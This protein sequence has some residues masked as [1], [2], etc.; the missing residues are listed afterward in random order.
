MIR[1]LSR[2]RAVRAAAAFLT[3]FLSACAPATAS[4]EGSGTSTQ[5]RLR[6]TNRGF[7]DIV[8]YAA[9]GAA[10]QRLGRV[11]AASHADLFVPGHSTV[12]DSIRLLLRVAGT[13]QT[14]APEPIWGRA[15]DVVELTVQ[16]L[17]TTSE[18]TVR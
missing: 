5:V 13:G 3:A 16:P 6:V 14:F 7:T 12:G 9:A 17:L 10:P 8:V 15:G 18:L 11:S 1:I 4:Y 2:G